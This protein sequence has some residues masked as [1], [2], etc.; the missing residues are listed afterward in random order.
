MQVLKWPWFIKAGDMDLTNDSPWFQKDYSQKK[1]QSHHKH[2]QETNS[3]VKK[4]KKQNRAWYH[5]S[6]TTLANCLKFKCWIPER[7]QRETLVEY[8]LVWHFVISWN[9]WKAIKMLLN[10]DQESLL[11]KQIRNQ[12]KVFITELF[13]VHYIR[14]MFLEYLLGSRFCSRYQGVGSGQKTTSSAFPW[15]RLMATSPSK[16]LY[17]MPNPIS[18]T[19]HWNAFTIDC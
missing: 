6:C 13:T 2:T 19:L 3:L 9:T 8:K 18:C 17:T 15:G 1:I 7:V 4:Q 16:G 12:I 10:F 11:K 5:F 14:W